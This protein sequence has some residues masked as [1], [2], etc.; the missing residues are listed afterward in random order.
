MSNLIIPGQ[1]M[2][3]IGGGHISRMLCLSAS[4]LGIEVGIIDPRLNCAASD[5]ASWQI[6]AELTNIAELKRFAKACD[7]VIYEDELDESVLD[8]LS[9]LVSIPQGTTLIKFSNNRIKE[10][11]F[12]EESNVNIAPF[13]VVNTMIEVYDAIERLGYPC[14][15]KTNNANSKQNTTKVIERIEDL[16]QCVDFL[17]EGPCLLE[18]YIPKTKEITVMAA[19]NGVEKPLFYPLSEK[20]RINRELTGSVGPVELPKEM[21][22]EIY[23]IVE[24]LALTLNIQGLIVIE[25]FINDM[26]I[27]YVNTLSGI[28]GSEGYFTEKTCTMSHFEAHVKG[29]CGWPLNNY[30]NYSRQWMTLGIDK[31]HYAN[32]LGQIPYQEEWSFNFFGNA[33]AQEEKNLGYVSLPVEE[34]SETFSKIISSHIWGD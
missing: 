17:V 18:S 11:Q 29:V 13:K 28:P 10:R 19:C 1:T 4:K 7:V 33:Q 23:R 9:E 32:A 6:T 30:V 31:K 3:I 16:S 27:I 26:G 22:E 24:I 8:T 2:G 34:V 15:L 5:V 21:R 20:I 12:L 14:I 25:M